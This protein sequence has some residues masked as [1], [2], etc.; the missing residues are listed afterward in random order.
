MTDAD[1][2]ELV[3][4][5]MCVPINLANDMPLP[6]KGWDW[7]VNT[8]SAQKGHFSNVVGALSI[9]VPEHHRHRGLARDLIKAMSTLAGLRGCS[10]VIA[11]VRP[12]KK[13]DYP[14]A[15]MSKYIDWKD[16]RGRIFD[17]WLRSHVAAGGKL[18][19][20]CDL[21]MVIEQP[22]EFWRAW[23]TAE[24]L[25]R[26]GFV[27]LRGGLAPLYLD[28][29]KGMGSYIEPNVWVWHAV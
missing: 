21:S 12:S 13:R 17:P 8:A 29:R 2:G 22:I 19:G 1:T 18:I 16:E 9:S 15:E 28:H 10:G 7:L 20:V 3:A 24:N 25:R 27:P 14:F 4:T 23:S 5:G 26:E 11:P 6:P